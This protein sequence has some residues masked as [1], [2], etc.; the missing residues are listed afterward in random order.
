MNHYFC[1]MKRREWIKTMSATGAALMLFPFRSF[2]F[3]NDPEFHRN[4]FGED[5]IWGTATAAHQSEG[6]WNIDGKAESIWDHFSHQ[7]GK[8]HNNENA[9]TACDFYNRYAE[10]IDMMKAM[11]LKSFRFSLSWTRILPEGTGKINHAG[12]DFYH[13]VIDK[14]LAAGIQPWITLYHWDLPQVLEDKGGWVNRE[15]V[16]WFSEYVD[17]C[18]KNYG[19]KVK[20][21]MVLNEP[22]AFTGL[23]YL[24][25]IHAPGKKGF[26]NFLPAAHHAALCQ[27]E[28]GRIIKRNIPDA[29]VGTT[30]SCSHI[31]PRS[32]NEKDKKAAIRID[33]MINRL[34][35]E[36]SL[37]LGYPI[38][39]IKALKKIHNYFQ[40]GDEDK[41][42]F[43]FDFIGL[44]NYTRE[45]VKHSIYPP[46]LWAK[47]IPAEK[48]NV[49]I[50]AMKWEVYP[51]SIYHILK[52]FNAYQGVKKIIITENGAAFPDIFVDGKVEDSERVRFLKDYLSQVLRAKKEGVKVEG[53]FIWSFMDNFEWA[54]GYHPRFGIVHVDYKTQ[55]RTIKNSGYWYRDFLS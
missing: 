54:E 51:E 40:P 49:P 14:C 31:D 9:D 39:A 55:Q 53:Y 36:P 20:H 47:N 25:G 17:V 41:L 38:D 16:N 35:I 45:V 43:D 21:W 34:F 7:K 50:T 18:T 19:D 1:E 33:A 32:V 37:G 22:M 15:I 27:A 13:R 28:G 3:D 23:G 6:A 11:N 52:K 5:F 26:S 12:L 30:F 10:D 44:Q 29:Q 46:T 2:S 42:K 48:R 24:L 4:L 8:I